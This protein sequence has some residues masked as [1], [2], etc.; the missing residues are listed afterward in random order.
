MQLSGIEFIPFSPNMSLRT[1]NLR[2]R[3]ITAGDAPTI[4]QIVKRAQGVINAIK[5][6]NAVS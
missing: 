5:I 1:R 2:V 3:H 6:Q 4:V